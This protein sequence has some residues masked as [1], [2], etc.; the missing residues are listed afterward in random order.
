MLPCTVSVSHFYPLH[1]V[2]VSLLSPAQCLCLTFIPCTV[3]VSL[4]SPAQCLCLTFSPCTVSVSHFYP[5]HS[6][7]VSLLSLAL[8]LCLTFIPCTVSMSHFYPLHSV[9]ASLF[10]PAQCLCLT[11]IP[12]TVPVSHFYPLHSV[13]VSLLSPAQYGICRISSSFHK[14]L[15]LP[16]FPSDFTETRVHKAN[17]ICKHMSYLL[18]NLA[19]LRLLFNYRVKNVR[20]VMHKV[21]H[22]KCVIACGTNSN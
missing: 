16:G 6:V 22:R 8:C 1:S 14:S 18:F 9:C 19:I 4:L 2:C 12:C 11:F 5:L 13:C 10:S 21:I 15:S 20:T 7:C 17:S 3:C